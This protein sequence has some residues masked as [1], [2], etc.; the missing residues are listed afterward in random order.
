MVFLDWV[1]VIRT[2]TCAFLAAS[3]S[4]VCVLCSERTVWAPFTI[5]R[6]LHR[7]MRGSLESGVIPSA[8]A[9]MPLLKKKNSSGVPMAVF[10]MALFVEVSPM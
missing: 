8:R 10:F 3:G 2:K 9:D 4:S 7:R 6:F 1:S 5:E